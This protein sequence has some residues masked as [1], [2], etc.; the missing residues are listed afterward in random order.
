[1][2]DKDK[3]HEFISKRKNA[4]GGIRKKDCYEKENPFRITQTYVIEIL[5]WD[6]VEHLSMRKTEKQERCMNC[7]DI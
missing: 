3:N 7:I 6:E 2:H 5:V 1:M 4:E